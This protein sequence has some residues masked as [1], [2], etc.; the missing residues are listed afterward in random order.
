MLLAFG[1]LLAVKQLY[2]DYERLVQL[3]G[4]LLLIALGI[5]L[6]SSLAAGIYP[7]WRAARISPAGLL[8]TQ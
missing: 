2:Q 3:N 8:K 7:A 6:A 4:P 5:A 1:G